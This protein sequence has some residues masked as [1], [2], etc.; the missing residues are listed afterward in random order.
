MDLNLSIYVVIALTSVLTGFFSSVAA[1]I[2]EIWIKP[3]LKR[4]KKRIDRK[5]RFVLKNL[6]ARARL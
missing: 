1:A 3:W 6:R 4:L 5:H 2:T